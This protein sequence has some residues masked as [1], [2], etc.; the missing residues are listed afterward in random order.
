MTTRSALVGAAA[1]DLDDLLVH[2]D[3]ATIIETR[4]PPLRTAARRRARGVGRARRMS[5][6]RLADHQLDDDRVDTPARP[7][8]GEYRN[9]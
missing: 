6:A 3:A 2:P 9:R 4:C 1:L 7:G 8:R 5:P